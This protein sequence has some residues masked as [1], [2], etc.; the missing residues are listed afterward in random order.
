MKTNKK[1]ILILFFVITYWNVFSQAPNISYTTPNSFVNNQTI[2]PL[3]PTNSGGAVPTEPVVSTFSGTG[4][5]GAMDGTS[6]VASF[7]YPTVVTFDNQN[8]LIVVDRSNHKIRS[9]SSTGIVTTISGTGSI[10]AADGASNV[11]TFKYPDGAIVDSQGNIFI[12]DQSN[13]KIRKIDINGQVTTFAGSGVA[14]FQDGI[15]VNSKFYFP[16]A[17]AI[18]EN[19]NLYVADYSNHCIRKVTPSGIVTTLAGTGIS[20]FNDGNVTVAQFNGPTGLCFDSTGVLYVADYGN[21]RIRKINTNGIVS[22]FAGSGTDGST[23][24][25]GVLASFSHPAVLV[26]DSNDNCYV[27]DSGNHKIRKIDP[28][29]NVST[30][31]GTGAQGANDVV[32]SLATFKEL[33]GITIN[34]QDE[35]F[36]ADY[37]N[38]KIRKIITYKYSIVPSLPNGLN[39]NVYTGEISGTPTENSPMTDYTV[40]VSNIFG[41]S[42]FVL[43]IEVGA[44]Q[45]PA[46]DTNKLLV[47]PNPT[48]TI[49]KIESKE[50]VSSVLVMNALGVIVKELIPNQENFQIDFS[51]IEKG[52]YFLKVESNSRS[53]MVKIVKN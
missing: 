33:T 36:I 37:A 27:T 31:A 45:T 39:F 6:T 25:L 28:S 23:D 24:D 51:T 8:N 16:A 14:G 21:N 20:G 35:L 50:I 48:T 40:E 43:G 44:L 18:D 38:H 12:T 47:F 30:F 19:D 42:S 41:S 5:I 53:K 1:H 11:A 13:H 49:L 52:V 46:F 10:G 4:T 32:V 15:G 3:Y 26:F 7:N 9:V 2:T 34:S 22:T 17:M 29:G